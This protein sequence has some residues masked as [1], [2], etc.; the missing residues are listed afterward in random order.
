MT[1]EEEK[2]E[3]KRKIAQAERRIQDMNKAEAALMKFYAARPREKKK[4]GRPSFWKGPAGSFFVL[5]VERIKKERKKCKTATA[6]RVA[7]KNLI[8]LGQLF[9]TSGTGD[10]TSIA[11]AAKLAKLTNDQELQSRYQ[12]A[13][14]YWL[15][16]VDPEAD[17]RELEALKRN[18]KQALAASQEASTQKNPY[19]FGLQA[20]KKNP[21]DFS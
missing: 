3:L 10:S 4:S 2:A 13:R 18:F 20:V 19:D 5:E 14:K 12:E 9:K 21:Y 8:R 17:E 15:F 7:K 1:D 16:I 6:I 11:L